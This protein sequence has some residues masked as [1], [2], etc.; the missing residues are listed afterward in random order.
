MLG[1]TDV[2]S[3]PKTVRILQVEQRVQC[4]WRKTSRD[5]AGRARWSA[6]DGLLERSPGQQQRARMRGSHKPLKENQTPHP[7]FN[8]GFSFYH[9][10]PLPFSFNKEEDRCVT[11]AGDRVTNQPDQPIRGYACN[12]MCLTYRG[13][14]LLFCLN[15]M[16]ETLSFVPVSELVP[17]PLF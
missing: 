12:S 10:G 4:R 5:L 13:T 17:T 15:W 11:S 8:N 1:Y 14:R 16:N 3:V 2:S 9:S 7:P 6:G